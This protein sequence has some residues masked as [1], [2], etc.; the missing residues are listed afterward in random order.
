MGVLVSVG[1]VVFVGVIVGVA[2]FVGVSVGVTVGVGDGQ[3]TEATTFN[4]T[5]PSDGLV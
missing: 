4:L 1:V 3:V 2:V 5:T